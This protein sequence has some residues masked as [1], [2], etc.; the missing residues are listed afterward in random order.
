[1]QRGKLHPFHGSVLSH[2]VHASEQEMPIIAKLIRRISIPE[3]SYSEILHAWKRRCQELK[4]T[5]RTFADPGIAQETKCSAFHKQILV[6]LKIATELEMRLYANLIHDTFIPD[7]SYAEILRV[8]KRR[9][10][11][12]GCPDHG[13]T[14][15]LTS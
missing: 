3:I 6:E 9:C 10:Q 7:S 2:I 13:V 12:I 4:Q 15:R 14:R 8:W 11:E 5:N 1:M